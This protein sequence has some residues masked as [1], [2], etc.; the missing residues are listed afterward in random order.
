MSFL[1]LTPWGVMLKENGFCQCLE[2]DGSAGKR[3]T[4]REEEAG[5]KSER[6]WS[7]KKE[8]T[9]DFSSI[10]TYKREMVHEGEEEE[11]KGERK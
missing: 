2:Q 10:D 9:E 6:K 8:V 11:G 7:G 4:K 1:Y 5:K 3:K